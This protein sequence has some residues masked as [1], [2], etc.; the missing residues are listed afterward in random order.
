LQG[1]LGSLGGYLYRV[2]AKGRS[3]KAGSAKFSGEK[4]EKVLS[5]CWGFLPEV[6]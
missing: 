2:E 3:R 4:R 5:F 6:E 1:G